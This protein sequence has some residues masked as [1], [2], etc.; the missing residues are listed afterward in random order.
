MGDRH[1][2]HLQ[3]EE[4]VVIYVFGQRIRHSDKLWFA[5][6]NMFFVIFSHKKECHYNTCKNMQQT[7]CAN[8]TIIIF[9]GSNCNN[10]ASSPTRGNYAVKVL[11]G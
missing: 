3:I 6:Q 4:V 10:E 5:I 1:F 8:S 2:N 9:T 7:L 11:A